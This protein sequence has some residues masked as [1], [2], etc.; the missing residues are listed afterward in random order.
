MLDQDTV[1]QK[2]D[3]W[4]ADFVEVPHPML[5]NWAPCPYAR[6]ARVNNKIDIQ[7][8]EV[9]EITVAVK[10]NLQSLESKD[11]VVICFDHN[12]IDPVDLQEY[13]AGM[14]QTLMPN[15][16]VMLE[17]HPDAPEFVNSVRMNFGYCGL[18]VLQKLDKINTASDQLR[19]K[20]YYDHWNTAALDQVVNWRCK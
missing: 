15:N 10:Q 5:G 13:T 2:L 20:G 11:A 4:L 1:R 3:A 17:D 18:L 7:F 19:V 8:C 9:A 14:N 6:Q 12:H 16:Y